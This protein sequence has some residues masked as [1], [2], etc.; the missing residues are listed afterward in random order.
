MVLRTLQPDHEAEEDS[1]LVAQR[2]V[3]IAR[4]TT[5]KTLRMRYTA[6][7]ARTASAPARPETISLL[8]RL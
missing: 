3:G 2:F 5:Q 8:L 1:H 7:T 6:L 4:S